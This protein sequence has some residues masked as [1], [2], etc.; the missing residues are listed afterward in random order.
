MYYAIKLKQRNKLL[1]FCNIWFNIND[2]YSKDAFIFSVLYNIAQFMFQKR[3]IYITIREEI[4]ERLRIIKNIKLLS[5][6]GIVFSFSVIWLLCNVSECSLINCWVA[7]KQ[8]NLYLLSDRHCRKP[9]CS[10][11]HLSQFP[12]LDRIFKVITL[13]LFESFNIK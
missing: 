8:S 1:G 13:V 7:T 6:F 9:S 5:G 2:L 3:Q 12:K 4:K 10:Q 11:L